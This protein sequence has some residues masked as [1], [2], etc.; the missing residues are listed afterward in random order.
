MRKIAR[1]L[2]AAYRAGKSASIGNSAVETHADG[3]A[4]FS[5]HG[6]PIVCVDTTDTGAP[7]VRVSLAG[8]PTPTTRSRIND[9]V[10][11]LCG[12]RPC[13]QARRVQHIAGHGDVDSRAGNWYGVGVA[14]REP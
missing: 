8:W 10:N 12:T 11:L 1:Q 6:H 4:V 2:V 9:I 7:S 3:S 5:L 14:R 13:Y